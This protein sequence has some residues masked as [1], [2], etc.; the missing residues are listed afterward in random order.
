MTPDLGYGYERARKKKGE[1]KKR[2]GKTKTRGTRYHG[3]IGEFR[4]LQLP[5]I[6]RGPH[7]TKWI[8]LLVLYH[9]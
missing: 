7:E 4:I 6:V 9:I 3:K 5:R 2:D 1:N 8:I